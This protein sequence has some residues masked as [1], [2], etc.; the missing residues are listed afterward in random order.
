MK[1]A[2]L[3]V[4]HV[5]YGSAALIALGILPL[6]Y[7][8]YGVLRVV[9][10]LAL[11]YCAAVAFHTKAW[12]T[13]GVTV[14][15]AFVFNPVVPVH[16]PK[17]LWA[18]IDGGTS[19]YLA[20]IA[21]HI[22]SRFRTFGAPEIDPS[23]LAR[24]V[25]FAALLGL[26]GGVGVSVL[27]G[28]LVIPLKWLGAVASGEFLNPLGYGAACAAAAAVLTGHAYHSGAKSAAASEA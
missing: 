20:V 11:A 8:F 27:A 23:A 2:P 22:Q 12:P 17:E 13:L 10:T 21:S 16:L 14:A 7:S 1:P 26:I 25:G 6:P 24:V 4:R 9:A 19:A 28:I 18:C 3:S 5:L 15:L